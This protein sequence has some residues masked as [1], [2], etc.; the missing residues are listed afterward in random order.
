MQKT[1][2]AQEHQE[3]Q[4]AEQAEEACAPPSEDEI[5]RKY[6]LEACHDASLHVWEIYIWV[7]D[8]CIK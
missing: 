4:E 8:A 2:T 3:H 1:T 7:S 6:V 5:F